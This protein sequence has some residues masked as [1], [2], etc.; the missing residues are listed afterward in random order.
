M[1]WSEMLVFALYSQTRR[2]YHDIMR[3]N[4][5]VSMDTRDINGFPRMREWNVN[6]TLKAFLTLSIY[7]WARASVG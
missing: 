5:Y 7:F 2:N 3:G 1:R 6:E 4:L